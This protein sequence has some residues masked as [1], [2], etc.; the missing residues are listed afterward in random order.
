MSAPLDVPGSTAEAPPE[1]VL[2]G[3]SGKAI[4]GRSLGQ[5][6][7]NRLK[8]DKVALTGGVTVILLILMAI[9]APVIVKLFGHPP[10]E[11]HQEL[12]DPTLGGPLARSSC[13]AWSP[14]TGVTCSAGSSTARGCRC[15]S[16]SWRPSSPW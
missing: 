13:S 9:F 2:E 4:Q 7:W 5:I 3:A 15:W 1:A 12:I 11:F 10:N 6:A 8:R 16:G 14:A